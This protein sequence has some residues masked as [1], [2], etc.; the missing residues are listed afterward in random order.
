MHHDWGCFVLL[1]QH[2]R[3][4]EKQLEWWTWEITALSGLLWAQAGAVGRSMLHPSSSSL[5]EQSPWVDWCK[6]KFC[7]RTRSFPSWALTGKC[8]KLGALGPVFIIIR[9]FTG[10]FKGAG[11]DWIQRVS[12]LA[13]NNPPSIKGS[14]FQVRMTSCDTQINLSP[15]P[16]ICYGRQDSCE[17]WSWFW[18]LLLDCKQ[19]HPQLCLEFTAKMGACSH[20]EFF[21]HAVQGQCKIHICTQSLHRS[22]AAK[23]LLSRV[24]LKADVGEQKWF[25][26]SGHSRALGHESFWLRFCSWAEQLGVGCCA[27][28]PVLA[29]AVVLMQQEPGERELCFWRQPSLSSGAGAD[30]STSVCRG[31]L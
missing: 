25:C 8:D 9:N 17:T 15:A 12:L 3:V 26:S 22:S 2:T 30:S 11:R 7:W 14:F 27:S 13:Q 23:I 19:T 16:T 4:P 5:T 18:H 28:V 31:A 20:N 24:S 21:P 29:G 1:E 6:L 10:T